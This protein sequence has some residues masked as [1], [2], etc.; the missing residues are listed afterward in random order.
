M[1]NSPATKP[2]SSI[3]VGDIFHFGD[4]V[5]GCGDARDADFVSRVIGGAKIKSVICDP[6]FGIRAVGSKAGFSKL[7]MPKNILND[8]IVS[9]SEYMQFT[10]DWIVPILQHF[11]RKNSLYIFNSD[12][13]IFA[14]RDGMER[15]GVKFSQLLV[16]IKNNGVIGRKDYI[17]QHELVAYGWYGTHEF[18]KAKDKSLLFCPRPSRSPLHPTMKPVSLIRRL[19]LNATDIGDVVFDPFCGSGTLCVAAEQVKRSSITIER[20]EAY[21]Q[22]ILTRMERLFGLKPRHIES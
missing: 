18:R 2:K 5:L 19:I 10:K 1:K 15:S 16:W 17:P 21:C 4:H 8:D 6:P 12:K 20:D 3:K 7:S 14:L 22:T 13:M 11:A 9:E